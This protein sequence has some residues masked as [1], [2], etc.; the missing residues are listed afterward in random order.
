MQ[1]TNTKYNGTVPPFC[2]R[3]HS[4]QGII[5]TAVWSILVLMMRSS[6]MLFSF[7]AGELLRAPEDSKRQIDEIFIWRFYCSRQSRQINLS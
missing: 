1:I 4:A 6:G 2:S 7:A 3:V 5:F